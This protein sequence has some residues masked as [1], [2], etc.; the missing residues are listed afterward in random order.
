MFMSIAL[1]TFRYA[2]AL[3]MGCLF[4]TL[5]FAMLWSVT[6]ITFASKAVVATRIEFTRV[7]RE[8]DTEP[9]SRNDNA[10][11]KPTMVDV[12]P[13]PRLEL[14]V[15]TAA[16]SALPRMTP[17]IDIRAALKDAG[18]ALGYQSDV[19][20]ILRIPPSYPR[21]AR[22][23]R[24]QGYVTMEVSISPEGTVTEVSV[25][26]AAP[27]RMFDIAAVE[28]MKRWKFRPK[29]VNGIAVGQRAHQ[30][31]EFKIEEGSVAIN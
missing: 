14:T 20:A 21:P 23:A 6:A 9:M 30:T 7:R 13:A 1:G 10:Q 4:T 29:V 8:P 2:F 19:I 31:I 12:P 27:P 24:I 25:V 17:T 28:A 22:L 26:D 3:T 5:L 18:S 16:P 11:P 15:A